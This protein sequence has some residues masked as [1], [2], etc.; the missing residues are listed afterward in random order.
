MVPNEAEMLPSVIDFAC[1]TG[2]FLTE[3]MDKVQSII[4]NE[5]DISKAK[6]IAR[7]K[8]Q[9]WIDYDKFGWAED[10]VYGIDAD[11][12]LVKSSKVSSFLNGDGEANIIRANGLD[13]FEKSKEYKVFSASSSC[14]KPLSVLSFFNFSP[15]VTFLPP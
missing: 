14:V 12:R 5:I 4:E 7:K 6:P 10:Y 9:G 2:H 13:H 8:L 1:G 3:Y 15:K 11:Y